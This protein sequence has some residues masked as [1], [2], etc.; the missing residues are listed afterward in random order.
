MQNFFIEYNICWSQTQ[1]GQKKNSIYFCQY[2]IRKWANINF[3]KLYFLCCSFQYLHSKMSY[4]C[5]AFSLSITFSK[6]SH[7]RFAEVFTQ[8]FIYTYSLFAALPKKKPT[9][10]GNKHRKTS[11]HKL[12]ARNT[13]PYIT[14]NKE[15]E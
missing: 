2:W 4:I 7:I 3:E 13:T 10:P 11:K 5:T 9:F 1:T 12:N 6:T 14:F 15:S 8:K